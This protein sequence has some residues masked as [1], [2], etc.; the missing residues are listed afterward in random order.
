MGMLFSHA[1]QLDWLTQRRPEMLFE[2]VKHGH[3]EMV[4]FIMSKLESLSKSFVC[5][6]VMQQ[7]IER[8]FVDIAKRIIGNRWHK[9]SEFDEALA[10]SIDLGCHRL[11]QE[12]S[13]ASNFHVECPL[14]LRNTDDDDDD[15][16]G[17]GEDFDEEDDDD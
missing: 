7:V 15:D 9:I 11:F 17:G 8:D 10:K 12:R 4:E 6:D 16:W 14:S 1:D 5:D 3:L 13:R 2:A